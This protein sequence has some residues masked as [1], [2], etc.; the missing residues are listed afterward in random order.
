M[1]KMCA[2]LQRGSVYL[3][4]GCIVYWSGFSKGTGL[5]ETHI[6]IQKV[7]ELSGVV[8]RLWS[9]LVLMAIS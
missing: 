2:T 8:H 7:G 6:S 9:G 4:L 3:K 5:T 1:A